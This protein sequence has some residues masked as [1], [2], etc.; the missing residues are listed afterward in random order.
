MTRDAMLIALKLKGFI[1]PEVLGYEYATLISQELATDSKMGLRLTPAGREA[2]AEVW[3]KE[4]TAANA[5]AL[6]VVYGRF[7][8]INSLFKALVTDWQIRDGETN[9]HQDAVYDA[10][11]VARL[12]D[13]HKDLIPILAAAVAQ[14]PR[15][16]SYAPGFEGALN[17]LKGGETRWMAAP[18]I[19][20]YHTLWFELHEELIHLT[21]R[22]RATEAAAGH[23][24]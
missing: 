7:T 18:I 13:V 17:K 6:E 2:A 19:D 24:A 23:G 10:A 8:A 20:S 3:A 22:T 1:R 11:I 15:L 9:I 14:V 21:G 5:V 16:A 4:L 12:D